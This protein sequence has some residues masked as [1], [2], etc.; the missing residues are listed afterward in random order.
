MLNYKP[1]LNY[2]EIPPI[3]NIGEWI[4]ISWTYIAQ[5]SF[6]YFTIGNFFSNE[7]TNETIH[8][9]LNENYNSYRILK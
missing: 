1:Q 9:E 3:K 4:T 5:D 8:F 7:K 2:T 6:K